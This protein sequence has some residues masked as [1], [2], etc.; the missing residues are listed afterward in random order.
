MCQDDII[1]SLSNDSICFLCFLPL[2]LRGKSLLSFHSD[3][4]QRQ[5]PSVNIGIFTEHLILAQNARLI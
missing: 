1:V 5:A 4:R 2:L 3:A